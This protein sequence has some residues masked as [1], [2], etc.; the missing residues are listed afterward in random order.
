M[1]VIIKQSSWYLELYFIL[2]VFI[3]LLAGGAIGWER[4]KVGKEAGIRT[5]GFICAGACAYSIVSS[6]FSPDS[7]SR[8]VANVVVGI[9]FLAGGVIFRSDKTIKSAQGLTTASSLWVTSTIGVMIGF[10]L[11]ILA[12]GVTMLTLMALH[13]PSSKI[14]IY[15]SKK[16]LK[17]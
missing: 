5:F 11:Y 1:E 8:I 13:L 3:A 6:F 9:G 4:E 12:I 14:W 10:D 17:I 7:A 16:H 15:L 2:K